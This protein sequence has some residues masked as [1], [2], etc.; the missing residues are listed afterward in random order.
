MDWVVGSSDN[1]HL[2]LLS[3]KIVLKTS[4]LMEM[5]PQSIGSMYRMVWIMRRLGEVSGEKGEWR[6]RSEQ[7]VGN[8]GSQV[9]ENRLDMEIEGRKMNKMV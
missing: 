7:M 1:P 4:H 2:I 6:S 9:G 8:R 3:L 5:N